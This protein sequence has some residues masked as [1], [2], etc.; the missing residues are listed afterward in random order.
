M[1]GHLHLTASARVE[2]GVT[3]L[4]HQSFRAPLH[5]SKPHLDAG[6]LV[7]N[8]VN[9]TAGL[10]DGDEVQLEVTAETGAH[11]V[12]TTPSACRVF[13][14]RSGKPASL[15]QRFTVA[16]GG[17]L[18]FYPEAFIP[19]AGARYRQRTELRVAK[20]GTLL[21][22]DWLSPGRSASGESF[23]Y[24]ELLWELDAWGDEH[25]VA[26]ER[27]RLRPEDDSLE[28]LLRMGPE[29]HY[30]S[31]FCLTDLDLSAGLDALDAL[32][33]PESYLGH[34]PLQSG[35]YVV[36]AL[37]RDSLSA[38]R[39]ITQLRS[40]LHLALGQSTTPALRRF[41]LPV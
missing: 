15:H 19:H 20:G 34:G 27:Y 36:K 12:L 4:S 24:Q 8:I 41:E 29:A 39:T 37:C 6:A 22:F 28:A 3:Y 23:R 33:S 13:R 25:L 11:V 10:F 38:R 2:D 40:H 7:V 26:R 5:L 17:F 16:K 9:P 30:L 31:A 21:Y 14:S 32:T 18:E 35:G 1:N